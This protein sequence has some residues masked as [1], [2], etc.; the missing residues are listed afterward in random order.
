[1]AT[2]RLRAASDV[3]VRMLT[4]TGEVARE[5][6]ALQRAVKKMPSPVSWDW[7]APR[8]LPILCGPSFDR[9]G[10][11][12][13]RARSEV[14]P[15]V[16]FGIDLGGV[17]TYVD[18]PVARRW[19]CSRDQ[20]M[21]RALKNLHD[22]A[23]RI[24]E[25]QVVSGVMSGRSIRLLRDR[26]GWASSLILDPEG[27]FRLFGDHD[28]VVGTPTAS[29]L[30]SMPIDTPARIVA[31]IIVDFERDTMRSLWLDPF[32]VSDRQIIWCLDDDD[33]DGLVG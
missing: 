24:R 15:M 17:F 21:D 10:E 6:R 22:R 12:L 23:C 26:P 29:I 28:Q 7:A 33:E 11:P 2:T 16:Q 1:M 19:E 3:I 8:I 20:L 13:V 4:V 30:L 14:G 27:L 5:T 25:T 9:P 18:E 32:V 31:E